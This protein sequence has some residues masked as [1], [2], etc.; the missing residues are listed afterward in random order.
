MPTAGIWLDSGFLRVS[1]MVFDCPLG[2]DVER[3]LVGAIVE[4]A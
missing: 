1:L 4:W 2:M 3:R